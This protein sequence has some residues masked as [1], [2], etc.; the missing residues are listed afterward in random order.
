M[1]IYLRVSLLNPESIPNAEKILTAKNGI[2]KVINIGL[3]EFPFSRLLLQKSFADPPMQFENS[4]I[5]FEE[6][7]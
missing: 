2:Q 1:P 4:F 5:E 3:V 6:F 7:L